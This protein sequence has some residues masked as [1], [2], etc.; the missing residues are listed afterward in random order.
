MN[1]NWKILFKSITGITFLSFIVIYTYKNGTLFQNFNYKILLLV[2]SLSLLSL[3]LNG[4][5]IR[6]S[7]ICFS[8]QIP[9]LHAFNLSAIGALGN[10]LGGIPIGTALKYMLLYKKSG[11]SI[12]KIT[13]GFIFFTSLMLF[14][15]LLSCSFFIWFTDIDLNLKLLPLTLIF[16]FVLFFYYLYY[17]SRQEH[18]QLSKLIRPFFS[19]EILPKYFFVIALNTITSVTSFYIITSYYIPDVEMARSLFLVSLGLLVGISTGAQS[20]G[21]LQ[22]LSM[23]ISGLLVNLKIIQGVEIVLLYRMAT[24][25]S[26]VILALVTTPLVKYTSSEN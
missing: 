15:L 3:V 17:L 19:F 26:S 4:L 10:T 5:I 8:G 20:I 2:S 13:Y 11:V 16:L 23:G 7:V 6:I 24:F 25:I 14:M 18:H 1:I 22:E 12:K 21:G 9:R